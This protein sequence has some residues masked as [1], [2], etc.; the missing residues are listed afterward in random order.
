M[1]TCTL[2]K[3]PAISLPLHDNAA[4]LSLCSEAEGLSV[5]LAPPGS[6]DIQA[7]LGLE[8]VVFESP[9]LLIA[10]GERFKTRDGWVQGQ[11]YLAKNDRG[12]IVGALNVTRVK[13]G[14]KES[15]IASNVFVDPGLRRQGVAAGLL[16]RALEDFPGLTADSSMSL[17]GAALTGHAPNPEVRPS[18]RPGP[19]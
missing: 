15:A 4:S 18:R 5:F 14:R 10:A 11:R 9:A 17:A 7:R 6:P 13:Q 19:R 16:Q 2:N 8:S 12:S 3:M 1:E